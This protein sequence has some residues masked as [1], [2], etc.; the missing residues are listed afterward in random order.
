MSNKD[1]IAYTVTTVN[2]KEEARAYCLA[3]LKNGST[4]DEFS[5]GY[6]ELYK[7]IRHYRDHPEE[8]EVKE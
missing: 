1:D 6:L 3:A 2:I 8:L 5:E 7:W 4:L